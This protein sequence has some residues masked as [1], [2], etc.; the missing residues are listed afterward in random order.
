M[1]RLFVRHILDAEGLFGIH[2]LAEG[3]AMESWVPVQI[4]IPGDRVE[5]FFDLF[6]RWLQSP[7]AAPRP[8]GNGAST[9]QVAAQP[10][11]VG[12]QDESLRDARFVY[13]RASAAAR[14]ILDYWLEHPETPISGADLSSRLGFSGPQVISGTLAS[15]GLRSKAV[16]R[17]LPFRYEASP[18]GGQY[19]MQADLVALFRA[20]RAEPPQKDPALGDS[21]AGAARWNR[22]E[23]L[24]AD[25]DPIVAEL[26]RMPG[27]RDLRSRGRNDLAHAIRKFGGFAALASAL[28]YPY[29]GH[30]GWKSPDDLRGQLDPIVAEL[31][32]MPSQA[33]LKDRGR[34]DLIAAVHR[35]GGL[36]TVAKTLGYS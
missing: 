18:G 10:W 1:T 4:P 21:P 8:V 25:L 17:E 24:R 2:Q 6:G 20:A 11:L 13:W 30:G 31:G 9:D 5:E 36:R 7:T 19:W 14:A 3:V 26:G 15:V 16:G 23:D 34:N 22:V 35:F 33:E 29:A 32:R 27:E 12:D 28:G